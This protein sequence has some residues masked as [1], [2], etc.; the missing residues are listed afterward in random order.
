M[1][2]YNNDHNPQQ[3]VDTANTDTMDQA[4]THAATQMAAAI[5]AANAAA[6]TATAL[7]VAV[8]SMT[9]P[10]HPPPTLA[11]S[12]GGGRAMAT[13]S[14]VEQQRDA[15]I[16][17]FEQYLL[18]NLRASDV[19]KDEEGVYIFNVNQVAYLV[20]E[21]TTK[22][23]QKTSRNRIAPVLGSMSYTTRRLPP[24][25]NKGK[26]IILQEWFLKCL[27]GNLSIICLKFVRNP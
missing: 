5:T 9:S 17:Q 18:Q 20:E 27:A 7:S 2:I 26:Y 12:S 24:P 23:Q 1:T 19:A 6:I 25:A 16:V 8:S 3:S 15:Q 10:P 4:A 11:V 21:S 13:Y 22:D 14:A